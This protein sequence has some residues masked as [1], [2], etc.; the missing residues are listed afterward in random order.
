M[1]PT[2]PPVAEVVARY[3]G[4]V[5]DIQHVRWSEPPAFA[6][7]A[8][9]GA[10][11]V[12]SLLGVAL[13]M[14]ALAQAHAAGACDT[15]PCPTVGVGAGLGALL[16]AL[17]LLPLVLGLVRWRDRGRARYT[18]GEAPGVDFTLALPGA[19]AEGVA[20]IIALEQGLVLG[21]PPGVRG[22]LDGPSPI[23][24]AEA[25]AQGRRSI[26]LPAGARAVVELGELTFDIAH[27]AP[28][29]VPHSPFEFD[30][31][32]W[33]SHIAAAALVGGWVLYLDSTP[34]LEVELDLD[35]QVELV[36]RYVSSPASTPTDPPPQPPPLARPSRPA[37]TTTP[38]PASPEPEPAPAPSVVVDE[39][40][41]LVA[42]TSPAAFGRR[43]KFA[44]RVDSEHD[45]DRVA[46]V[47]GDP[48]F[49]EAVEDYTVNMKNGQ[50]AYKVTAED[51]AWW[52]KATG[53]PPSMGKHFGGL[54]LAE[55]ERGGGVHTDK[56]AAKKP[57]ASVTLTATAPG[58]PPPT[59]EEKARAS[60]ISQI[61][62]DPPAMTGDSGIERLALYDYV[63]KRMAP[64]RECYED[65]LDKRPDL[66]GVMS[67]QVQFDAQGKVTL[68]RA[69]WSTL[70]IGVIEKCLAVSARKWKMDPLRPK[71]T[72]AVFHLQFESHTR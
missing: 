46:G 21:L 7:A 10:G 38:S 70:S 56:P 59:A 15:P 24:L 31:L 49:V 34:P 35:A 60:R 55:T 16:I 8:Y 54:E 37:T 36:A 43:S 14:R 39:A 50:R 32:A 47:L 40:S 57:V 13:A 52:A 69:E 66:M 20:L 42:P 25:A 30:R 67:F 65:A 5:V 62:M 11:L 58:M 64:W 12:V 9:L 1:T 45:F 4:R 41:G 51:D 63:R 18:V 19:P 48:A 23:D 53:G 29:D 27:V 68:A 17:G 2:V 33:L 6:P 22:T 3:R 28:A 71:P 44:G 26:S 72:K 61:H